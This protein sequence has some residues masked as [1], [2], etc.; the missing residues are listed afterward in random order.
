M[1]FY[2]YSPEAF[3]DKPGGRSYEFIEV[4]GQRITIAAKSWQKLENRYEI[5]R[6]EDWQDKQ[7]HHYLI[8]PD[9]VAKAINEK[10]GHRGVFVTELK[11]DSPEAAKLVK[12]AEATNLNWRRKVVENFE[13][14]L[15]KVRLG[16]PGRTDLTPY[17][18][19]CYE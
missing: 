19:E 1:A 8:F 6:H 5:F 9:E 18:T 10:Y 14:Q 16:K 2:L 4:L 3:P 15:A 13:T 7:G 12:E 11:P 17:E